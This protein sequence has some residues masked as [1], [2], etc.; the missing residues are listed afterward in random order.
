[1]GVDFRSPNEAIPISTFSDCALHR[2]RHMTVAVG[3]LVLMN[4]AKRGPIHA[5]FVVRLSRRRSLY[6]AASAAAAGCEPESLRLPPHGHAAASPGAA[7]GRTDPRSRT[8]RRATAR[9]PAHR[10][11][12]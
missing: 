8:R 10:R 9:R 5:G 3:R 6:A 12:P 1:Q 11:P 4:A 2:F 7:W